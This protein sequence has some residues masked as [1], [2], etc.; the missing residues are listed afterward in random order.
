MNSSE[1]YV[2]YISSI[3]YYFLFILYIKRVIG[4][5]YIIPTVKLYS[6]MKTKY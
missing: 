5:G 2:P 6:L 4:K 1:K 3:S